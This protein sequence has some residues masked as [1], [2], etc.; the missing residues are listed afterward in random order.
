MICSLKLSLMLRFDYPLIEL[1]Q[2]QCSGSCHSY[3][4]KELFNSRKVYITNPDS[5]N[6]GR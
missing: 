1:S 3:Q 2:E 4:G 6:S 5:G